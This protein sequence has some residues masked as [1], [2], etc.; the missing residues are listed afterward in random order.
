MSIYYNLNIQTKILKSLKFYIDARGPEG[1]RFFGV[2]LRIRN[3]VPAQQLNNVL[4]GCQAWKRMRRTENKLR[5]HLRIR[6]S[7]L[8]PVLHVLMS[9]YAVKIHINGYISTHRF[10]LLVLNDCGCT[11]VCPVCYQ[12]HAVLLRSE[13]RL[14]QR[15]RRHVASILCIFSWYMFV[16]LFATHSNKYTF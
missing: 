14:C 9:F 16:L 2:L 11:S 4:I 3:S 5:R 13:K 1:P 7:L 10:Y 15:V 8:L 6:I 12:P